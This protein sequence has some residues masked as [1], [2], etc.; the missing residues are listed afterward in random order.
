MNVN[1]QL[2]NQ[3]ANVGRQQQ[4]ARQ[5]ERSNTAHFTSTEVQGLLQVIEDILP[6]HG[7]EWEDVSQSHAANFPTNQCTSESLKRKFQQLYRVKKLTGDPFCPP[8]VRMAKRLRH[9][10]TTKCE[11]DDAEGGPLPPHVSFNDDVVGD[12]NLEDE[13][14]EEVARN[15]MVL[16]QAH[17]IEVPQ[18]AHGNGVLA[19]LPQNI[20][21]IAA[22][23][24]RA[25]LKT[26]SDDILEVYK[27]KILQKEEER[28]A[29]HERYERE[30]EERA[31]ETRMRREEEE[32]RF[33]H[34]AEMRKAEAEARREEMR[35]EAESRREEAKAF[36][37]MMLFMM[38]GKKHD[39]N[40][41]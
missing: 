29:E 17:P 15:E 14:D 40:N 18:V 24:K 38:L 10:I 16:A 33:R 27:L 22:S 34:E 7:E 19:P 1:N 5:H 31:S 23:R 26:K 25:A 37:E 41:N 9:L 3:H 4:Q 2:A 35:A 21:G 13:D 20:S 28:E 8:D 12:E 32:R 30:R 6:V 36:H 39:E 11:I